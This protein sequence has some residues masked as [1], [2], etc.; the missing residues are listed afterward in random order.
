MIFGADKILNYFP[1]RDTKIMSWNSL[2]NCNF[3]PKIAILLSWNYKQTM[4]K[5]LKTHGFKGSVFIFFPNIK[6]IKI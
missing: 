3:I 2:K 5:K 1:G 4:I 6:K